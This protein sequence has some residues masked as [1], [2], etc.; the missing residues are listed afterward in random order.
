M[1]ASL[2]SAY[3][4]VTIN[5]TRVVYPAGQREVSLSMVNDGTEA[6]LIQ[7]WVAVKFLALG[8]LLR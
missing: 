2:S 1:A 4:G 6:R 8:T 3:A 5:G 7:A